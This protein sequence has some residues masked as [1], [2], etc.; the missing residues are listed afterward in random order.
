MLT[1]TIDQMVGFSSRRCATNR[2]PAWA[3]DVYRLPNSTCPAYSL[4]AR[5]RNA[6]GSLSACAGM[7]SQRRPVQFLSVSPARRDAPRDRPDGAARQVPS[8]ERQ[9]LESGRRDR[10]DFALRDIGQA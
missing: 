5:N 10:D 7:T 4:A 8:E 6:P 3:L 2:A 1:C 9:E